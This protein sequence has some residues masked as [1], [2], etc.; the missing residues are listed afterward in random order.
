ML[1]VEQ[2]LISGAAIVVGILVGW[3]RE[4][5]L[6]PPAPAH[7]QRGGAGAAVPDRRPQERLGRR[8]LSVA[9]AML[10]AGALLFRWIIA[11]IRIHQALKLGEE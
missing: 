6:R 11:R 3:H 4:R 7:L 2:M 9:A 10:V 8:S 1:I 5:A